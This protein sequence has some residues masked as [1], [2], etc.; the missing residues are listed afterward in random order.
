MTY[1]SL[2][3]FPTV[4]PWLL[5]KLAEVSHELMCHCEWNHVCLAVRHHL[6]KHHK[7]KRAG[8]LSKSKDQG[9]RKRLCTPTYLLPMALITF[10]VG[11]QV[12]NSVCHLKAAITIKQMPKLVAFAAATRL[13]Y[14]VPRMRVAL[15][16]PHCPPAPLSS[17][18]IVVRHRCRHHRCPQP[19]SQ[20]LP[21]QTPQT[22]TMLTMEAAIQP[23]TATVMTKTKTTTGHCQQR[24]DDHPES[25]TG[26]NQDN[27]GEGCT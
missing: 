21:Q 3:L 24:R 1:L 10:K 13:P 8:R 7:K 17:P 18:A 12:K 4:L 6:R 5:T 16:P 14:Q 22:T 23:T 20:R 9:Q 27:R 2:L 25:L 19:S 15:D 11:C 26:W